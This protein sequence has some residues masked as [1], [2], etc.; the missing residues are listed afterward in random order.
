MTE[1][2]ETRRLK[3]ILLDE[4]GHFSNKRIK[5]LDA[6]SQFIVDDRTKNDL[7]ANGQVYST[8][9]TMFL[10]VRSGNDVILSLMN[11][12]TSPDIEKWFA[13]NA[14]AIGQNGKAISIM[15]GEQDCT[16]HLEALV[17]LLASWG[18]RYDVP[19]YKYTAPRTSDSLR[20]LRLTL[21][22]AW[23]IRTKS[24]PLHL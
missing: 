9:C 13:A 16:L 21:T 19:Y 17:G 4:Y 3:Q 5:K 11:C 6:G 7:G 12:P 18:G 1:L 24:F 2:K 8:F 15:K 23:P 22:K 14:I 10:D 20:R